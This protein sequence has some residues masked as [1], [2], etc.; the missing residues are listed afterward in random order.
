MSAS[1]ASNIW[2]PL[3]DGCRLSARLWL[4]DD[5]RPA[6]AVLEYIPYP[7]D[8][9][10]AAQD[11][12]RMAW[13]AGHGYAGLRVDLRGSGDSDGVLLDEYLPQEQD[14]AVEAIAWI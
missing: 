1:R 14:D 11:E 5:G 6:P 9:F 3:G 12:S 7:K 13:F 2:I 4:P 8:H 10:T